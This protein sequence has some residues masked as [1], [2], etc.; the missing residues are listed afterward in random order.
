MANA[1]YAEMIE[2]PVS[3]CVMVAVPEKKRS[4]LKDKLLIRRVNKNAEKELKQKCPQKM[5]R[6]RRKTP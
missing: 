2:M 4:A 1:E 6:P 5:T 3:T